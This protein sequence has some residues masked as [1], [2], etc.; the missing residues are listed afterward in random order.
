MS[1]P[2]S[3]SVCSPSKIYSPVNV[4]ESPLS[5]QQGQL[6]GLPRRVRDTAADL[7]N[8]IQ[9]WNKL[10]IGGMCEI[11]LIKNIKLDEIEK[12]KED[13]NLY[14][15]GLQEHCDKLEQ[16]CNELKL[17]VSKMRLIL[18][19]FEAIMQLEGMKKVLRPIFITWSA[20]KYVTTVQGLV[21]SYE[22]EVL[23]KEHV[24]E[25]IGHAGKKEDVMLQCALW[26]HQ[27]YIASDLDFMIEAMLK[28]TGHR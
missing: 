27:P 15:E 14:P 21:E 20:E 1:T 11:H 5:S 10:H 23:L 6:T 3:T 2:P 26:A 16:I 18:K 9:E 7:F 19:N 13:H 24:K 17:V 8:S 4:P 22:R 25:N 28:E 12:K